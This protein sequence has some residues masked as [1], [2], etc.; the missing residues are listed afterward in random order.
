HPPPPTRPPPVRQK[1]PRQKQGFFFAKKKQKTPMSR[2]ERRWT[3]RAQTKSHRLQKTRHRESARDQ[4][5][6]TEASNRC[7]NG[8]DSQCKGVRTF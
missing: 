5:I 8:N 7:V 2:A 3:D 6:H 1:T 4:A